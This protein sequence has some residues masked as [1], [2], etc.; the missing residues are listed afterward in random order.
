MECKQSTVSLQTLG[1][2]G[3]PGQ[4][5]LICRMEPIRRL[6]PKVRS[7]VT[8]EEVDDVIFNFSWSHS[9]NLGKRTPSK[10]HADPTITFSCRPFRGNSQSNGCQTMTDSTVGRNQI[11]ARAPG[12]RQGLS[13]FPTQL[14]NTGGMAM[15]SV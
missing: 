15:P 6:R 11:G 14:S 7:L 8:I 2:W 9:P 10:L 3:S 12:W 13:F 5:P 1:V 4:A